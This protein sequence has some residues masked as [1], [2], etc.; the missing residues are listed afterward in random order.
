MSRA[1]G[2]PHVLG[3]DVG[4]SSVRAMLFDSAAAPVPGA[5]AHLPYQPRVT[6]TGGAEVSPRLIVGLV[7]AAVDSVAAAAA[8]IGAEIAAVGTSTFWHGLLPLGPTGAPQGP[9]LLWS[10][11]RSWREAERLRAELD[12]EAVR[13]RT[14]CPIHPTYWP[15]KLLWLRSLKGRTG[16]QT[17]WASIGDLIQ[18]R[19]AGEFATSHSIA[20]GTGL[21]DL[22]QG[23]W[24]GDLME[25]VGVRPQQ[26]PPID[27]S[28]V[29]RLKR[30]YARRW[31]GLARVPWLP[32]AGD[33][34]LA[35]LG[36]GC[37]DP[38]HRA[39]TIGT[40]GAIRVM[41]P[42]APDPLPPGLWCYV[43]DH[44]RVLVGG[45]FSN[46]G[47]LY[48]WLLATLRTA[49]AGLEQRLRAMRPAAH[50]LT[51]LP[52]LAGERSP[53]FALNA[54]GAI[55]GLTQATQP[56][57]IV[58]AAMESVA[59]Q[60]A[61]VDRELD[62]AAPGARR[63]VASG[64][65]LLNSEAWMRIMADVLQKPVVP[66]LT[67]EASCRGAAIRALE[68]LGAWNGGAAAR[69]S[70]ARAVR[71]SADPAVRTAY[72]RAGERQAA[73]HRVLVEDRLLQL[74]RP[75][76]PA[77]MHPGPGIGSNEK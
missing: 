33:G 77:H 36:S 19:F 39:V 8:G 2:S 57:E 1:A 12:G 6:V 54:T 22:R 51:F 43:L 11:G 56:D 38:L 16:R 4:T 20:S 74:E 34:A 10:D 65:A 13:Q 15:S 9:L 63:V 45:A 76:T 61:E 52:L 31:P 46:G 5:E 53:T 28:A 14:G 3:I 21:Y 17:R 42:A 25:R 68:S 72:E 70:V 37:I 60:F 23:G 66:S 27:G 69:P 67:A 59:I 47:N 7:E 30:G 41:V 24:W 49:P 26:L 73:L 50:G 40:S 64:A 44:D 58:R 75:S 71:P 55:A 18:L 32:A 62:T 48:A 35:N 29:S